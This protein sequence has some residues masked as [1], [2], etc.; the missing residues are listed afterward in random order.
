VT[1][2]TPELCRAA[3]ALV[4]LDQKGLS[5]ASGVPLPTIKAFETVRS[6][7]G[8][9]SRRLTT[10]NNRALVDALEAAGVRFVG[11][12]DLG[13]RGVRYVHQNQNGPLNPR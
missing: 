10:L 1:E 6:V 8:K 12:D 2:L 4:R 9:P 13:G 5:E 7:D 11:V 3:R